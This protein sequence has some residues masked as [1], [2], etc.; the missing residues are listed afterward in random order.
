MTPA[1]R[2]VQ[3]ASIAFRLLEFEPGGS[4]AYGAQAAAAL[5]LPAESVFKTL[6][7]KLDGRQL[8][9]ALVPVA[10]ELDLKALAARG[11]SP[12]GQRTRLVTYADSS[13]TRLSRVY[14]SGGRRGLELELAPG[15]LIG[16]CDARIG[17]IA[18]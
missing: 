13:V 8:V 15:D 11:I 17:A 12:L 2:A 5:G 4:R 18:R 14:V 16:A 3:D 9:V 6:I 1:V 10:S 7:A